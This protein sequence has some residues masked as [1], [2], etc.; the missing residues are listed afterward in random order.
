M[1]EGIAPRVAW[2]AAESEGTARDLGA[3]LSRPHRSEDATTMLDWLT[4]FGDPAEPRDDLGVARIVVRP[5]ELAAVEERLR[6]ALRAREGIA[7]GYL[8]DGAG[9][10]TIRWTAEPARVAEPLA[11]VQAAAVAHRGWAALLFL[12]PAH[13]SGFRRLLTPDPNAELRRKVVDAF[14][15]RA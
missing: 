3:T 14:G 1:V 12:P 4:A 13:R 5:T 10:L 15:A 8:A 2:L 11:D 9:V 7:A 6:G